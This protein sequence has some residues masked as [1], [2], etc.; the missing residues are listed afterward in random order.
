MAR[1]IYIRQRARDFAL[2][3][4]AIFER[5]DQQ[6]FAQ[7]AKLARRDLLMRPFRAARKRC[8]EI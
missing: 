5:G 4:V 1:D 6:Q 7:H 8:E 3:R 2:M